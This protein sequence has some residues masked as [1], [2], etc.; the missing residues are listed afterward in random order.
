[1]FNLNKNLTQH[2]QNIP[3]L[4]DLTHDSLLLP[5]Y[6][7]KGPCDCSFSVALVQYMCSTSNVYCFKRMEGE[8]FSVAGLT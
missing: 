7:N 3:V 5:F 2:C 4:D 1:M 8:V 6:T